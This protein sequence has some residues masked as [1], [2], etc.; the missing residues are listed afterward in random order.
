MNC[1]AALPTSIPIQAVYCWHPQLAAK[2][3]DLATR[4]PNEGEFD[5]IH[6]EHLRGAQYGIFLQKG[7]NRNRDGRDKYYPPI[8]WDSVDCITSLFKRACEWNPT[9]FSQLP[10]R[11][12]LKRTE[13]Y[14]SKLLDQFDRILVTSQIDK[15]DLLSLYTGAGSPGISVLPNGVDVDYFQPDEGIQ[16]ETATLVVS[17]KMSYHA[18]NRMVLHLV[19]DIMPI[20]WESCPEVKVWVVGKD[21]SQE[22]LQL[23]TNPAVQV[24]GTVADI[25]P[26]LRRA[27]IAVAP[28]VYGAGI[29]NKVLEAMA[30]GTPVISTPRAISAL[31]IQPG[32]EVILA[33]DANSFAHSI[34]NLL[35][36]PQRQALLS[37]A[38]RKYAVD[39]HGWSNI[40][41]DLEKIYQETIEHNQR[42]HRRISS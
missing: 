27:T 13:Q 35:N 33:E 31:S 21:P 41:N 26:Y 20:V 23:T 42:L 15:N 3:L 28:L 25:R 14:E 12:D 10:I 40:T 7:W 2:L 36:D 37:M 39:H 29:Q 4:P 16:R 32:Q 24:T 30:C 8:I 17:G 11:L 19:Q 38:G 18:N 34:L 6:V 22:I 9:R 1:I 5:V